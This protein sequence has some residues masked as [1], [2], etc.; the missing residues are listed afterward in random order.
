VKLSEEE[1]LAARSPKGGWTRKTLEK[2][3]VPWPP[4]KGWK[5]ELTEAPTINRPEIKDEPQ[6][7]RPPKAIPATLYVLYDPRGYRM[8]YGE[9]EDK[10]GEFATFFMPPKWP[11]YK[12]ITW[13]EMKSD[14]WK[15][16]KF[17]RCPKGE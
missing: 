12:E 5:T 6:T 9:T 7:L 3:G 16:I 17:K 4:P 11:D 14:G 15:A 13:L 2:W 1:I 10:L 8:G